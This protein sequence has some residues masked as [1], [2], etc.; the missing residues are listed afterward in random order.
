MKISEES[1]RRIEGLAARIAGS[2]GRAFY[3]GGYVRDT[4]LGREPKDMD[5]EVYG[6]EPDA[7][8]EILSAEGRV[9]LVGRQFGVLRAAGLDVDWT[10]PR[11][12]SAGRHPRVAINPRLSVREASRRRDLTVNAMLKDVLT[13]EVIDPWGGRKDLERKVLRAPDPDLFV[14]DP[15][16][17]YRVMQ[18]CARL[19]MR[20]DEELDRICAG[21]E[22]CTV[23]RERVE[24]EFARLLLE[25]AR[26]S[27]GLAWVRRVGRLDEV[28]PPAARLADTPQDPDWHPEGDV[29]THT[30]QVTD[31]AAALREGERGRD[32]ML[33]WAALLHDTGK[34]VTT[35]EEDGHLRSPEHDRESARLAE[36]FLR[37]LLRSQ[38]VA[39]GAL[40]L[41][42]QHMKPLQFR[43]N[44]SSGKAFK[45]LAL[46]LAP[47][48]DLELLARLA[49]AD[50]RGTSPAGGTPLTRDFEMVDWFREMSERAKVS[51]EPEK[52][53]LKGR[54]LLGIIEP[55]PRLGQVL[56]QA[57]RIQIEEGIR[58]V[59][60][61]KRRVILKNKL[62]T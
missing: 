18:L 44:N 57:Y 16:R 40:K 51:R 24:D 6:L 35:R 38:R 4:L 39:D 56:E 26:P 11:R 28:L 17:F 15:L 5:I 31:A 2:G 36:P 53:V 46:K 10:L 25:A 3:V 50:G 19:E 59:E 27:L 21:M 48:A 49:L 61:L 12:D 8:I 52:P 9:D 45:R 14:E 33:M 34:A 62:T 47:E 29:W 60:E 30:L 41:I 37:G 20:P 22:I 58:E 43:Q 7:L 54:H 55:G 23:A 42:E 13:G 1:L 32:L